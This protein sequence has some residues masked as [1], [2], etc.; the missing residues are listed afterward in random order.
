MPDNGIT[1]R[2][3]TVMIGN[4]HALWIHAKS[5]MLSHE[6]TRHRKQLRFTQLGYLTLI[7]SIITLALA[8][9]GG[10]T[11]A[12]Q[13]DGAQLVSSQ[14]IFFFTGLG[15]FLAALAKLGETHIGRP[16]DIHSHLDVEGELRGVIRSLA[17]HVAEVQDDLDG[18]RVSDLADLRERYD[19]LAETTDYNGKKL[20]LAPTKEAVK[21]ATNAIK[22]T[23]IDVA[24]SDLM[25]PGLMNSKELP[26]NANDVRML[27]RGGE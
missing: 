10:V 1:K 15:A 2:E 6:A 7:A 13:G 18:F 24:L 17:D 27:S 8:G 4:A 3:A 21:H 22:G 16:E 11:G 5:F 26:E 25:N 23:L 9:F 20:G 14:L 12:S 19:Q